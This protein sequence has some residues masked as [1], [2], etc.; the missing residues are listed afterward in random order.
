[1]QKWKYNHIVAYWDGKWVCKIDDKTYND[2]ITPCDYMG[3]HGW[4]LVSTTVKLF[5][6]DNHRRH[7][8]V[9]YM[10]TFKMPIG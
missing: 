2:L 6:E 9:S 1:M 4:E 10:F 3:S 8:A 7:E 5:Q